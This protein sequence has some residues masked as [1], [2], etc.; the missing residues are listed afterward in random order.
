VINRVL[1]QIA[2]EVDR[3]SENPREALCDR[4]LALLVRGS[5]VTAHC[6]AATALLTR[7]YQSDHRRLP[8]LPAAS[9]ATHPRRFAPFART[10]RRLPLDNFF[11]IRTCAQTAG[12]RASCRY[13]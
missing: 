9:C 11:H 4:E 10:R 2:V 8:L 7:E 3:L 13:V 5:S 1:A 6:H 12:L